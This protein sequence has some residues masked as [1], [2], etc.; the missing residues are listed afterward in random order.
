M[1]GRAILHE[2][3][4]GSAWHPNQVAGPPSAPRRRARAGMDEPR[5]LREGARRGGATHGVVTRSSSGGRHVCP[6]VSGARL[7]KLEKA[8]FRV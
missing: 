7:T 2:A 5:R 8:A 4:S 3:L 1:S 6:G